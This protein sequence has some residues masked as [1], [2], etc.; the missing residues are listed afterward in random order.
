MSEYAEFVDEGDDP[1]T[2]DAVQYAQVGQCHN[3]GDEVR[4]LRKA[5]AMLKEMN[6]G[7]VEK[8]RKLEG[9]IL[10]WKNTYELL[11]GRLAVLCG[12]YGWGEDG[13]YSP[14]DAI[15]RIHCDILGLRAWV[16]ELKGR[17]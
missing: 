3:L 17:K 1:M 11:A 5:N 6:D 13:F 2:W 14:P 8:I 16:R 15:N 12:L 10:Y 4:E 7:H 9:T